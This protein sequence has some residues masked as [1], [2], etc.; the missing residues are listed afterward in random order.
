MIQLIVDAVTAGVDAADKTAAFEHVAWLDPHRRPD[1]AGERPC[2]L[3]RDARHRGPGRRSSPTTSPTSSTPSRSPSTWSTTRTRSYY[4][5]LHRAQQ[6]APYRPTRI[7]GDLMMVGQSLITVRGRRR[8]LFTI[9]WLVGLIVVAAALPSA[10]VRFRYSQPDVRVAAPPH[11]RASAQSWYL[12][13]LLTDGDLRQG[14]ASLRASATT[15][16]ELVPG[17]CGDVLRGQRLAI[18]ARRSFADL[19]SQTI[20]TVAVFG[21]FA[22]IAWRTIQGVISLGEHDDVLHGL[23]HRPDGAAER[24]RRRRRTLRGQPLP[25]LLP[26]LHGRSSRRLGEPA[27]AG[28]RA[29]AHDAGHRPS[30]T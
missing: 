12:H 4:D 1:R 14:A 2:P 3:G 8:H 29:A 28:A 7:V 11:G 15:F 13:W 16:R 6:E 5:V 18:A 22:Y 24:A 19:G 10:Y 20:A 21:T 17:R 23:Q 27:A 26:R 25:D 9:H 30:A